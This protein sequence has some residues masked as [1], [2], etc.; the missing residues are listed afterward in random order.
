M[1]YLLWCK[2]RSGA[3]G[4]GVVPRCSCKLLGGT[5]G[6]GAARQESVEGAGVALVDSWLV[7]SCCLL[8]SRVRSSCGPPP[9]DGGTALVSSSRQVVPQLAAA[10]F[11]LRQST[12]ITPVPLTSCP[13]HF[14]H[15][16]PLALDSPSPVNYFFSIMA[17]HSKVLT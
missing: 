14:P 17:S 4:R 3:R 12:P 7:V 16:L 2:V 15:Y 9:R 5:N 10:I 6:G 11:S 1:N 8:S 13:T